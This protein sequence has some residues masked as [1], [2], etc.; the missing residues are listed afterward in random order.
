MI[1]EAKDNN[2]DRWLYRRIC[3]CNQPQITKGIIKLVPT[4]AKDRK[5]RREDFKLD[6]TIVDSHALPVVI[7]LALSPALIKKGATTVSR[8]TDRKECVAVLVGLGVGSL[9]R[10]LEQYLKG[11]Y[12]TVL[13]R[14][15]ELEKIAERHFRLGHKDSTTI[16]FADGATY[17]ARMA[18]EKD[19]LSTLS[20]VVIDEAAEDVGADLCSPPA[21]FLLPATISKILSLLCPGGLLV[22]SLVV[23]SVK[24]RQAALTAFGSAVAE[25][26][27]CRAYC[28]Y[29]SETTTTANLVLVGRKL[30]EGEAD[31]MSEM[32][33]LKIVSEWITVSVSRSTYYGVR[34][35]LL[36]HFCRPQAQRQE[37]SSF[38]T[39]CPCL[40]TSTV[41]G[42]SQ[43]NVK[44]VQMTT[45]MAAA[46][47]TDATL[48]R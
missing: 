34:Y 46:A 11:A 12:I 5:R 39:D 13:E 23:R 9:L 38:L 25:E 22:I 32:E 4:S 14:D 8:P 20:L 45:R 1:E 19:K 41:R 24:A 37:R 2:N 35:V 29:P 27:D 47:P 3:F 21:E 30:A 33:R 48:L 44:A 26:G 28:F 40:G 17:L 16:V 7:A 43:R 6:H 15:K 10:G 18:E 42:S 31:A 36:L